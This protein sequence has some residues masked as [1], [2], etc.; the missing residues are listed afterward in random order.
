MTQSIRMEV[1]AALDRNPEADSKWIQAAVAARVAE[2]AELPLRSFHARYVL[3]VK[4]QRNAPKRPRAMPKDAGTQQRV[5]ELLRS[6]IVELIR[7]SVE[8]DKGDLVDL[9]ASVDE[10]ADRVAQAVVLTL[11][12]SEV[13]DG[14]KT[15]TDARGAASA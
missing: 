3:P 4:R 8:A 14:E 13:P 12:C 6:E 2:A 1:K 9:I 15:F 5:R 10:R 7:Q 11:T